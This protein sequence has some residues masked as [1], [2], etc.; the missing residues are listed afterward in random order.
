MVSSTCSR[1]ASGHSVTGCSAKASNSV[2][3]MRS[4]SRDSLLT[5]V[6]SCASHS[7]GTVTRPE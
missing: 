2:S 3:S 1:S 7:T 6:R 4:S 5:M